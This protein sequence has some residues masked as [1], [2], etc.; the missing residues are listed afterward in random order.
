M[1]SALEIARAATLK[2]ITDI[3]E[4]IGIPPWLVQPYGEHVA[5]LDLRAIGALADRP[6]LKGAPTGWRLPVREVRASVGT[7]F[8]YPICGDMRTMPGLASNS[9]AERIDI[10]ADGEIAGLA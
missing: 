5:K 9:A 6:A 3:A 10:D 2:P 8:V 1:S 7:G 4:D